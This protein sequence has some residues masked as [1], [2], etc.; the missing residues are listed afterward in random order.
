MEV[1]GE[2][3][4]EVEAEVE[5]QEGFTELLR[6][7]RNNVPDIILDYEILQVTK[8]HKLNYYPVGHEMRERLLTKTNE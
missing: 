1:L 6:K 4:L 5:S 3:Q 2:W 8:E 7:I